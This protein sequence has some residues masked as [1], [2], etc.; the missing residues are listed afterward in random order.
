V[1]SGVDPDSPDLLFEQLAEILRQQLAD[2]TI[3]PRH[4]LPTQEVLADRYQVS[5]GTVLKATGLLTDEGL[6]RWVK[7]RGLF[8]A[9]ADT[10][11][12]FKRS[13]ARKR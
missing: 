10:I 12:K 8:S 1:A 11:E 13:R 6:I 7:G 4:K 9:D 2:G 5:R 3:P